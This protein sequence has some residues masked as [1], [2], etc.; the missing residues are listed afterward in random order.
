MS[1]QGQIYS[2][3]MASE[4]EK[5]G[6]QGP[7]AAV[8]KVKGTY[9]A[10]DPSAESAEATTFHH[11]SFLAGGD[12]AGAGEI[13]A[14]QG[15]L[16]MISNASGHYRPGPEYV[17]QTLNRLEAGGAAVDQARVHLM[18]DLTETG[19]DAS[20]EVTAAVGEFKEAGGS[21][22]ELL[23]RHNVLGELRGMF[24]VGTVSQGPDKGERT[25]N[26]AGETVQTAVA[27]SGSA[28]HRRHKGKSILGRGLN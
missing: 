20:K 11:S 3:D 8:K 28:R 22:E 24:G 16:S 18:G 19:Y 2:A 27:A 23:K 9:Y 21:R 12:I 6:M 15:L 25:A 7:A 5:G 26:R 13:T 4:W 1:P 17:M 10:V 14:H